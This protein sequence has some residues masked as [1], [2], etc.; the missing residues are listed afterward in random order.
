[1]KKAFIV[2]LAIMLVSFTVSAIL[3][4]VYVGQYEGFEGLKKVINETKEIELSG[5]I[6]EIK[7]KSNVLS[8]INVLPTEENT[9][10]VEVEEEYYAAIDKK[11]NLYTYESGDSI[12]IEVKERAFVSFGIYQPGLELNLYIPKTYTKTLKIDA[13]GAKLNVEDGILKIENVGKGGI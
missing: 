12:H 1:M 4:G 10:R 13:E 11:I 9:I 2:W 3:V 5:E 8:Y 6:N 7:V